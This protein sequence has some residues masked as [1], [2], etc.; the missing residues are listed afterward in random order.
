MTARE[1]SQTLHDGEL[2]RTR[3]ARA[4]FEPAQRAGARTAEDDP[5]LP[6]RPQDDV[7]ALRFPDRLLIER[8]PARRDDRIHRQQDLVPPE[9]LREALDERFLHVSLDVESGA[10]A[11]E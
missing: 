2:L 4:F 6:R 8:V 9:L 5:F 10:L 7:D 3:I 11:I 1:E